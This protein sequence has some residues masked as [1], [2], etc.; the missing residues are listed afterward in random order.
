MADKQLATIL[1]SGDINSIYLGGTASTDKV[2][3]KSD[4]TG[5]NVTIDDTGLGVTANTVQEAFAILAEV[6]ITVMSGTNLTPQTIGTSATK[7]VLY[8]TLQ[9]EEGVGVEGDFANSKA[10]ITLDGVFKIRFEAFVSYA[11]NVD[12][13][14]ALYKNGSPFGNTITLSGQGTNVFPIVLLTS[15]NLLTDDVLELYATA[16]ASTSLTI[17]QSNGTLEKTIF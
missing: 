15:T 16:T 9:V 7:V 4:L 11:S 13:T 6:G 2:Q 1:N 12:I 8:D 10:T 5:L 3:K 17:T 14:W